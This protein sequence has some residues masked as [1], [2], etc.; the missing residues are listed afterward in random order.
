[1]MLSTTPMK[2]PIA[3]RMLTQNTSPAT[4]RSCALPQLLSTPSA[5]ALA[6]ITSTETA[7]PT[8]VVINFPTGDMG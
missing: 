1:M 2:K 5:R 3:L 6:A 4:F 8:P 7:R